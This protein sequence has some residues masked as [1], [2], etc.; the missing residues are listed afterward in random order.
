MFGTFFSQPQQHWSR[1]WSEHQAR[2]EAMMA[3]ADKI[4]EQTEAR[5]AEVADEAARLV[6]A[7]IRYSRELGQSSRKLWLDLFRQA[8]GG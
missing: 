2:L 5:V 8:A 1:V 6:K 3:E 7:S 4:E